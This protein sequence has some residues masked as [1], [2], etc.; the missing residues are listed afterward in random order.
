MVEFFLVALIMGVGLLGLAALS[1]ITVRGFGGSRTRNTASI[2]ASNVLDRL[3]LDGRLTA[4]LRQNSQTIP[5]SALIANATDGTVNTYTDPATGFTSFDM[6]GQASSV[7]PVF[8]VSWVRLAPKT[9]MVPVATSLSAG[10]ELV[11]NVQWNEA[12]KN[13]TTGVATAQPHYISVS[14][15]VRY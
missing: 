3:T 7:T 6:L 8:T 12:V 10:S 14:R 1:A 11:V 4:A 13:A 2:L 15:Y 9:T 5:A